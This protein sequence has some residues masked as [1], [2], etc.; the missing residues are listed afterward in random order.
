MNEAFAGSHRGQYIGKAGV[1]YIS[2]AYFLVIFTTSRL[3]LND[4]KS[5]SYGVN[6][7]DQ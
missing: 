7:D 3:R 4:A 5:E 6:E 2:V 1:M